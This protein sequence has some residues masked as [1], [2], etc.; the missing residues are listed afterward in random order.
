M[1]LLSVTA[2][3]QIEIIENFDSTANNQVPTGWTST[4]MGASASFACGGAGNS[5]YAYATQ[6]GVT[7]TATSP[8]YTSISNGTTLTASFTYN[9]FEQTSRFPP[10]A[11]TGPAAGWGSLKLEYTLDGST[12]VPI[13]TIDDSNYTFGD[14]NTCVSTGNIDLGIIANGSDFQVRFVTE[15]N[16]M[17]G[18][19]LLVLIDNVSITQ[20]SLTVPNCD[21]TLSSP[22]NGDT[23]VELSS[24]L[25]WQ[26]AT[27][28]PTGYTL[29]IGTTSGAKDILDTTT[30]ETTYSLAGLGLAYST[31]YFVNIIPTNTNGSATTGCVEE[32]FTTRD[33]P[34]DGSTCSKPIVVSSFPFLEA[35]DTENFENTIDV[36]PC[37]NN[38]MRGNDVFYQISPV[39]DMSI[40][41]GLTAVDDNGAS[42]HVVEGC[43]DAATECVAY[44]GAFSASAER[45]LD[46]LVL[47]GGK[48]YFVVLSNSSATRT[49]AYNLFI[50]QNSC[51]NPTIGSLTPVADCA[52]SQFSVEV[53]ISYLGD[54]SSL[55]LSD[56]YSGTTDITNISATGTV[57][58]GPYPSGTVVNFTLMNDSDSSCSY[59][60]TAYFYCPP[61]NDDCA[62]A[63]SL[64]VNTDQT[65]TNFVSAS[66]AG[67]TSAQDEPG[68][69][70]TSGNTVWYSFVATNEITI[71]EYLNVVST[72]GYE[73]GGTIQATELFDGT[74]G[75]FISKQCTTGSYVTFTGLTIGNTYYFKNKTNLG[76]AYAQNYDICLKEPFAAPANDDCS[77]AIALTVSTDDLCDNK[78]T[79]TTVGA[80]T[81][82]ETL[83]C[84]SGSI[85][86]NDVWYSFTPTVDG[87]YEF[88]YNAA[89]TSPS[90]Y[91]VIYD[92]TCGAFTQKSS[93]CSSKNNQI[94]TMYAG[95]TYY[96]LVKSPNN[97]VGLSFDI[98]VFQLP[99]AVSNDSCTTPTTLV[100]SADANGNNKIV[101]NMDNAYTS[102]ESNCATSNKHIWYA[103]TATYTGDYHVDFTKTSGSSTYYAI[104]DTDDCTSV[105]ENFVT[106]LTSCWN[107][108]AKTISVE[109]GKTYLTSVYCS[110]TGASEFELFIYPDATLST[111]SIEFESFK[112]FPNPVVNT[113]TVEAK[114]SISNIS[115]INI[116]GQEV[117]RLAPNT[118][119]STVDM[120]G[121][122]NGIYFVKVS[123]GSAVKT[124]KIIKE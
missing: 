13:T 124:F 92:G 74:C 58:A 36:S 73:S 44:V 2:F 123:I 23:G 37:N 70:T 104:Y 60:D 8:T 109:A 10:R 3:A 59:T 95:T 1:M 99:P 46:N 31:Q 56:D 49:Y 4:T 112:Y 20:E 42:V 65:C 120:N 21:A 53:D 96:V 110:A 62:N 24:A 17:N 15:V 25:T 5:L 80:T 38:Y 68:D 39:T 50:E 54:A 67:A 84:S 86:Y 107:S 79:G 75:S 35:N 115:V 81:S 85:I 57:T 22:M 14:E 34:I 113:L 102:A 29:T 90:S 30:T 52:N 28:L 32:S 119:K 11:Y 16:A 82:S 76:G 18:Y 33:E 88:S 69:C 66:N 111:A 71:L 47:E 72:P 97:D 12:W 45:Q 91:Y 61:S 98:C 78:A 19:A 48:T 43:P 122:N 87:I 106:G 27:G 101:G 6:A 40:N 108:G 117:M 7:N 55:T 51:I 9:I 114:N 105:E 116:V 41:I 89:V 93:S 103:F 77:N 118:V 26:A 100:E 94:H 64:T 63:T 121:L 83:D